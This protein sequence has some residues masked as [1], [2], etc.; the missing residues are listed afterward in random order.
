MLLHRVK[1]WGDTISLSAWSEIEKIKKMFVN[2]KLVVK[3][4][5]SYHV[6]LLETRAWPYRYYQCKKYTSISQSHEYV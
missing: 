1:V 2:R 4:P 6:M 3:F 5:T